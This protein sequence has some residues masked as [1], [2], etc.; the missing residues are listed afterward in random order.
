MTHPL[1]P[2]FPLT[3]LGAGEVSRTPDL[4]ITKRAIAAF[5]VIS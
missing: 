4:L 2:R 3:N 5:Q 1:F